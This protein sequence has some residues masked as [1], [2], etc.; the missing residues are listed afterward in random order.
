LVSQFAPF[1]NLFQQ[2]PSLGPGQQ[3]TCPIDSNCACR[4]H[5]AVNRAVAASDEDV[6]R[7]T[8]EMEVT[9]LI[10]FGWSVESRTEDEVVLTRIRRLPLCVNAGLV[11]LTG[12][13]WLIYWVPRARHPK[14]NRTTVRLREKSESLSLAS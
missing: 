6:R 8:A 14:F 13:L 11:L 4:F 12:F 10:D 7:T 1:E 5:P 3:S 2:Q 9:N